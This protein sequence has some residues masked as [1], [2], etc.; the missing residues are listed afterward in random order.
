[1]ISFGSPE[2][3][4]KLSDIPSLLTLSIMLRDVARAFFSDSDLL[5]TAEEDGRRREEDVRSSG[6]IGRTA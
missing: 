3:A 1:V 4:G 2:Q 6:C 5:L